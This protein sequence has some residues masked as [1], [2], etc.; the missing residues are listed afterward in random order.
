MSLQRLAGRVGHAFADPALLEQALTHRSAGSLHNERLEFLGD[1][2]LSFLMAEILFGQFPDARE[3]Q[4]TR[5]RAGLVKGETLAALARQLELGAVLHLGGGELKSG[6]RDRDSILA[7][8]FEALVGAVLLDGGLEACRGFVRQVYRERLAAVSPGR[9]VKD[10]K[11]RLQEWLQSRRLILPEY[12]VTAVEG[13]AHDQ[14]F[15]VECRI[16]DLDVVTRGQG[17]SR[18][19]AEQDAAVQALERLKAGDGRR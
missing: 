3:G 4:L 2:V 15:Q 17:G 7:D 5:L 14:M 8:A 11:T 19:K 10:P 12:R 13:D 9:A 16:A 6:G 1:A 18:R